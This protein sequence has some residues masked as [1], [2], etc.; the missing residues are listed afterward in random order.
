MTDNDCVYKK[1]DGTL[2]DVGY[3]RCYYA[4]MTEQAQKFCKYGG[5]E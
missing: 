1:K 2:V 5:G 4:S 3:K